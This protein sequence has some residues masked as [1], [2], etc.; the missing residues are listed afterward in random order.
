MRLFE[1][2][3]PQLYRYPAVDPR[4]LRGHKAKLFGLTIAP[5]RLSEIRQARRPNS[6]YADPANCRYE[7]EEAERLM[8]REGIRWI[9]STARS[10]EEIAATILREL[11]IER[12]S[13]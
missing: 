9:D 12:H 1:A 8:R 3:E 7:V 2:I 13:Y 5:Q 6:R 4:A 11:R 10:I